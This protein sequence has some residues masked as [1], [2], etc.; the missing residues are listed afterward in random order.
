MESEYLNFLLNQ[1]EINKIAKEVG[2]CR[3]IR[4]FNPMELL[5]IAVFSPYNIAKDIL[6]DISHNTLKL[7]I[8]QFHV[9]LSTRDSIPNLLNS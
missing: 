7:T 6:S 2:L 4:K 8:S 1:E 9:K 3:R 5:K